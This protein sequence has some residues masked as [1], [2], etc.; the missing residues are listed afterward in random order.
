MI[1]RREKGNIPL[2]LKSIQDL[3]MKKYN[4][5]IFIV[6]TASS[7]Y[8]GPY[9]KISAPP[10]IWIQTTEGKL[11]GPVI[12]L[13]EQ[14]FDPFGVKVIAEN[15]PWAKAVSQ[16]KTGELDMI[17]VIFFTE[18][19]TRFMSFSI[20]YVQVSTAVFVPPGKTF[21]FEGIDD[22]VGRKGVMI[23]GD[24]I[25]REFE[26]AEF[27]LTLKKVDR[28][29]QILEMLKAGRVDYAVAAKFGFF[30]HAKRIRMEDAYEQLEKPVAVRDLHFAISKRS[31]YLTCLP[32][33]NRKLLEM[34]QDGRMQKIIDQAV[35]M[36][37][38]RPQ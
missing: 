4:W 22:L 34:K 13:V 5:L 11:S 35:Q 38:E 37:S 23:A 24:S 32:A 15:L 7:A 10:S 8:A 12:D 1:L 25:S 9:I 16:I 14:I 2:G 29:H 31:K 33:I 3:N 17:P 21:F 27:R 18:E 30:I 19:R 6:L 28:Y 36:A 26:A 20:P